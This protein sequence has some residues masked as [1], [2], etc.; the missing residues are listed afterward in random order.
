MY[1]VVAKVDVSWMMDFQRRDMSDGLYIRKEPHSPSPSHNG[2]VD[3]WIHTIEDGMRSMCSAYYPQCSR[4]RSFASRTRGASLHVGNAPQPVRV[5]FRVRTGSGLQKGCM[6]V[7]LRLGLS[8]V[9]IKIE[10]KS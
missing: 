6:S 1:V 10:S 7:L 4:M 9:R 3:A 2:P 5:P 8:S